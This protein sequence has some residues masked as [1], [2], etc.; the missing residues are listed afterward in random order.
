M[1]FNEVLWYIHRFIHYVIISTIRCLWFDACDII[2]GRY[3]EYSVHKVNPLES[4]VMCY[5]DFVTA[6]CMHRRALKAKRG[7]K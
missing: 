2:T 6:C 1:L 5:E 4:V 3:K 7:N